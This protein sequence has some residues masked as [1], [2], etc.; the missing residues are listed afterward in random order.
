MFRLIW[1][2][3]AFKNAIKIAARPSVSSNESILSSLQV[4]V[5]FES[6]VCIC[7]SRLF[8]LFRLDIFDT[9]YWSR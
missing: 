8:K 1:S 4:T 2:S 5:K 7:P 6:L 9:V 3:G